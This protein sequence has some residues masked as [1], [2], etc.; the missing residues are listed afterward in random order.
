M[1]VRPTYSLIFLF[2]LM[3]IIAITLAFSFKKM[4]PKQG[5]L[6][7][8]IDNDWHEYDVQDACYGINLEGST[9]F[10]TVVCTATGKPNSDPPDCKLEFSIPFEYDPSVKLEKANRFSLP[11][12]EEEYGNLNYFY[13]WGFID[14]DDGVF[15]TR[16]LD[17][18]TMSGTLVFDR[19][20]VLLKANFKNT[21]VG[22]SFN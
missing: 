5:Q 16:R 6:L 4:S 13:F 12:Y 14:I 3:T 11:V 17:K 7:I 2:V 8:Q 1:E 10:L 15:E 19:R 18:T 22:R 21:G 20:T 9:Y